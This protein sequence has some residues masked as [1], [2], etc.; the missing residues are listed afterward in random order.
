MP[1]NRSQG[2]LQFIGLVA[3]SIGLGYAAW[4]VLSRPKLRPGQLRVERVSPANDS[5]GFVSMTA[6][7]VDLDVVAPDGSRTSTRA[8]DAGSRIAGSES[9]VD[10]PGFS[11]PDAKESDCTASVSIT[12]PSPGDYTVI[13]RS[14]A[15]RFVTLNVGWATVSQAKRG[16]FDVRLQMAGSGATSFSIIVSRNAVSLRSEPRTVSP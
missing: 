5:L 4:T 15:V 2:I 8:V 1:D 3:I 11:N 12:A 9:S 16:A 10:C 6:E 13:A 14:A 7:G